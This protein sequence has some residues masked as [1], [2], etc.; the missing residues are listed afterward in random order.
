L[1]LRPEEITRILKSRIEQYDEMADFFQPR[2]RAKP[3][4][5]GTSAAELRFSEEPAARN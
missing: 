5:P 2:S 4:S 1:K 3:D